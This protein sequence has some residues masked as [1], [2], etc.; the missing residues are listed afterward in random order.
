MKNIILFISSLMIGIILSL[1]L[2]QNMINLSESNIYALIFL[3]VFSVPILKYLFPT[4]RKLEIGT[5]GFYP[6]LFKLIAGKL[7]K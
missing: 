1:I 3:L 4:M 6:N 7:K 5:S 2:S